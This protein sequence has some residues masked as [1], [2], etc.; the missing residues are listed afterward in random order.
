M[1]TQSSQFVARCKWSK[2]ICKDFQE[3]CLQ[4]QWFSVSYGVL[5]HP[6]CTVETKVRYRWQGLKITTK[7]V[8]SSLDHAVGTVVI[9]TSF[10]SDRHHLLT[11]ST[12]PFLQWCA[13][14]GIT[15]KG[16]K[17]Q[18][19]KSAH[20]LTKDIKGLYSCDQRNSFVHLQRLILG[21]E[22]PSHASFAPPSIG[23]HNHYCGAAPMHC[24]CRLVSQVYVQYVRIWVRYMHVCVCVYECI[25]FFVRLQIHL[26]PCSGKR[27]HTSIHAC[28]YQQKTA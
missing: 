28:I 23:M 4:L 20:T 2:V 24:S 17:L 11:D 13:L 5:G 15:L 18:I 22:L 21:V 7:R 9:F 27:V 16:R 19:T 26:F 25:C 14:H 10:S 8:W 3:S 12:A 6:A 1:T